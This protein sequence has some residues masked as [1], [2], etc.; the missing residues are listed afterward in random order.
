MPLTVAFQWYV[1]RAPLRS[2]W[3]R[4][5]AS[6]RLG[7]VGWAFAALMAIAPAHQLL[8]DV[9]ADLPK[10]N[11][12]FD[13]AAIAGTLATAFAIRNLRSS[14]IRPLLMCLA[15][16][17]GIGITIMVASGYSAGFSHLSEIRRLTT[18]VQ[19]LLMMLGLFS[20]VEEVAFRGA[21]DAHVFHAGESRGIGSAVLVSGLWGLWHL[22]VVLNLHSSTQ[23]VLLLAPQLIAVHCA[24]GVPL[25]IYWRRS[26]NLFVTGFTHAVIDAVRNALLILPWH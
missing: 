26:S 20:V 16:A 1:R 4:D 12:L 13:S 8:N 21:F 7:R 5:A 17:G 2:L 23:P 18:G 22:P 14:S 24:I 25:S 6:F 19:S 9:R 10:V 15:I 11:L 3:V